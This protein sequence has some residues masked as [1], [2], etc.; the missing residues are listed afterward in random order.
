MIPTTQQIEMWAYYGYDMPKLIYLEYYSNRKGALTPNVRGERCKMINSGF[1][2][3]SNTKLLK[4]S[5][6]DF[7][8]TVDC[9][10][11]DTKLGIRSGDFVT[12]IYAW[13]PRSIEDTEFY[14]FKHSR[15]EIEAYCN[16]KRKNN[17]L[18]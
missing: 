3:T 9:I 1:F 6:A 13:K 12:G 11:T 16:Y 14:D 8:H 5:V 4:S 7:L 2:D 10:L 17:V 18:K 15:A